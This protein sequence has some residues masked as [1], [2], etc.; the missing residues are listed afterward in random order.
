MT[1]KNNYLYVIIGIF[2]LLGIGYGLGRY[3]TPVKI[4]EKIVT[5]EVEKL[6]EV[7]K[8]VKVENK[9]VKTKTTIVE[10][11]DGTKTT[12]IETEDKSKTET[13][14]DTAKAEEKT[15]ET[16]ASKVTTF[17][18]PQWRVGV[19]GG[20]NG[21]SLNFK[22]APGVV[23]GAMVE[24]RLFGPISVGAWGLSSRDF[25]VLATWEF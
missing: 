21:S 14:T 2:L 23:Y 12:V 20:V 8:E 25:G 15:K 22:E 3:F 6:V 17:S 24:K 19:L 5:K 1:T 10:E 18:K 11:K 7:I 4:E 13:K 9:D 16:E